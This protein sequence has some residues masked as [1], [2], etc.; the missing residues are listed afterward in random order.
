MTTPTKYPSQCVTIVRPLAIAIEANKLSYL[1]S[2]TSAGGQEGMKTPP[3]SRIPSPDVT[4]QLDLTQ[5]LDRGQGIDAPPN[6]PVP[7]NLY[8]AS[9]PSTFTRFDDLLRVSVIGWRP[10]FLKVDYL[11]LTAHCPIHMGIGQETMAWIIMHLGIIREEI[12]S[13]KTK[14]G[15]GSLI[16]LHDVTLAQLNMGLESPWVF[17]TIWEYPHREAGFHISLWK[18]MSAPLPEPLTPY[19]SMSL[20][21]QFQTTSSICQEHHTLS[22]VALLGRGSLRERGIPSHRFIL[23]SGITCGSILSGQ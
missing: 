16:H 12:P 20:M 17:G 21:L 10:F 18:S 8:P 3:S 4:P 9:I 19:P 5:R 23:G 6:E 1:I 2:N 7:G 15:P 22:I 14:L 13:D 11:P